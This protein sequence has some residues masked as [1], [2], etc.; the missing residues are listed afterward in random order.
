MFAEMIMRIKRNSSQDPA[1]SRLGA[2]HG[3]MDSGEG[4]DT[5]SGEVRH[6]EPTQEFMDLQ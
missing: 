1:V 4:G 3:G 2:R 6:G 5:C